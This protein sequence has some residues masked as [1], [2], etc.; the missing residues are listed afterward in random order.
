[1]LVFLSS[2][3]PL[4]FSDF[5]LWLFYTSLFPA[6]FPSPESRNSTCLL[7][8]VSIAKIKCTCRLLPWLEGPLGGMRYE[9]LEQGIF[10]WPEKCNYQVLLLCCC[11]CSFPRVVWHPLEINTLKSQDWLCHNLTASLCHRHL[12]ISSL[13]GM[14]WMSLQSLKGQN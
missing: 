9:W 2:F 14:I 10:K 8:F 12:L 6:S 5:S 4:A 13:Y 7:S 1:M 3:S 11:F